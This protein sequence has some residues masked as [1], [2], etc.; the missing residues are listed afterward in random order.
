MPLKLNTPETQ[1]QEIDE[2]IITR[3]VNDI[4]NKFIQIDYLELNSGNIVGRN[5][6]KIVGKENIK[7]LYAELDV[8]IAEGHVF[9]EASTILL[10]SKI[11]N[12]ED[13]EIV[14]REPEEENLVEDPENL[15]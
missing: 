7:Q 4:E 13:A 15:G 11:S 14:A 5:K 9:E 6:I 1:V 2:F 12:L 10:Y 3:F 8:I